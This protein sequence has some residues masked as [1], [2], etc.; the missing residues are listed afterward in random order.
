VRVLEGTSEIA[1]G[2]GGLVQLRFE[3]PVVALHGD[4]FILRSY[5]PSE[6]IAGGVIVDPFATKHR[7]RD[8][9]NTLGGLRLLMRDNRAAKLAGFV[10]ASGARGLRFA[11]LAAATGWTNEVLTK[12]ASEVRTE[13]SVIEAGGVYLARESLDRLSQAVIAE[14]ERHH[15]REPLA[16]GMLRET[17][18]EKI[19]T[20]SLPEVFAGVIGTLEAEG[21]VVSKK[22]IVRSSGH[23]V[24]LSDQDAELRNRIEQLYLASGVEAPSIDE[25]MTKAG[26]LTAQRP[27]A[28]KLMQLLIDDRKLVRIQVEM[29]MHAQVLEDLKIRLLEYASKHEPERLIDVAAFKDLAGVSRK[30]AIPLLEYFDRE[31]ITRRAGDKRLI[32]KLR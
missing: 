5:S 3:A 22:D 19:F 15:K 17:L 25:A 8:I 11:D 30:Y 6:T 2:K 1:P 31:Q 4:R 10:N 29:F 16:R 21:K 14:L 27:Q 26:V 32:L 18:R 28:R 20:H 24:G 23:S 9:E 7:G 13:G 12:T